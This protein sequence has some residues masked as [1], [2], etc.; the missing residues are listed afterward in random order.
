MLETFTPSC[1]TGQI[2]FLSAAKYGRMQEGKCITSELGHM[3]CFGDALGYLDKS[4]SG[5]KSCDIPV[6]DLEDMV[7]SN[8]K[9][10][11]F[12]YLEV[13]YDCLQGKIIKFACL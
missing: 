4:C 2:I 7:S 9:K 1:P 5:M 11:L 6:V 3:G 10:Q 8:C 13:S 12:K